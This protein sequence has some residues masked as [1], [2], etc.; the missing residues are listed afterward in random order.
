MGVAVLLSDRTNEFRHRLRK[1]EA[2]T[3]E[4]GKRSDEVVLSIR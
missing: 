1:D 2:V 4:G 3:G